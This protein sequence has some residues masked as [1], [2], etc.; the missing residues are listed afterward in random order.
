MSEDSTPL[1]A[2]FEFQQI[3]ASTDG[4]SYVAPGGTYWVIDYSEEGGTRMDATLNTRLGRNLE[5]DGVN[6]YFYPDT[7]DSSGTTGLVQAGE[8]NPSEL[9]RLVK[10]KV[11]DI[12]MGSFAGALL[13]EPTRVDFEFT[14]VILIDD[15]KTIEDLATASNG[16]DWED[17]PESVEGGAPISV[18]DTRDTKALEDRP[19]E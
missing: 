16:L 7:T 3:D 9:R 4:C 2:R 8:P 18:P 12:P 5:C 10:Y 11:T 6:L 19:E 15:S 17:D 13:C 14:D 1:S